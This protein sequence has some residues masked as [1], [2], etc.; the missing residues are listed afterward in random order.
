[1]IKRPGAF[2]RL[3][4][5]YSKVIVLNANALKKL[6]GIKTELIVLQ[7]SPGLHVAEQIL[8]F[9]AGLT[10]AEIVDADRRYVIG[11]GGGSTI[12]DRLTI[13]EDDILIN[14]H[15]GCGR[16]L[17]HGWKLFF[18]DSAVD[19]KMWPIEAY[20]EL[21]KALTKSDP[22]VRISVTGTR[23]EAYLARKFAS[24]VPRTINL[25][26]KT[27]VAD[28]HG[29]MQRLNLFISHD[30][31][32][33]HIAAASDVPMVGLFGPTNPDATGPYPLRPQH[34]ILK[35]DLMRDISVSEVNKAAL[36][37]LD[38]VLLNTTAQ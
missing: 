12:M 26:G 29:L 31:G 32:V 10:G 7:A 14:V 30:C 15:L 5:G 16:T 9:A 1:M 20:I 34:V 4:A 24:H 28:L 19:K 3:A 2:D 27:T 36:K 13:G 18:R 23:N 38:L 25:A 35:K 21:G 8:Q 6:K 17:L 37:L 22:R 33:M 11:K